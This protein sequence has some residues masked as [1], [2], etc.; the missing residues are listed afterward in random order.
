MVTYK[1]AHCVRSQAGI[2]LLIS[3][4]KNNWKMLKRIEQFYWV[5]LGIHCMIWSDCQCSH[6]T[7][8][9]ENN[10]PSQYMSIKFQ[11]FKALKQV[12]VCLLATANKAGMYLAALLCFDHLCH[13]VRFFETSKKKKELQV[14]IDFLSFISIMIRGGNIKES[15]MLFPQ[16]DRPSYFPPTLHVMS[17]FWPNS[18]WNTEA[19]CFS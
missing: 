14:Y 7:C 5:K 17:C 9:G 19:F 16:F 2:M 11:S 15:C 10:Q 8:E 3:W 4:F 1:A 18:L 13:P 12:E 6:C